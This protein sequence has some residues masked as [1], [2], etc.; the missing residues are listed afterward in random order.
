M[1]LVHLTAGTGNFH[2]GNCHRDN[3]LVKAL[4]RLGH[5][6]CIVPLYLPLVLDEAP[7]PGG[8]PLFAGGVNMFLQQ[9]ASLFRRTPRWLDHL[10]DNT[11]LLR[12]AAT[13][14]GMTR[15]EDL[16]EMTVETFRGLRGRQAKEWERLL[17]WLAQNNPDV[18]AFSNGLLAGLARDV[19]EH[20][21]AAVVCTLQGEDAFLDSL[22]EPHRTEAW[23]QM[24]DTASHV[25][26]FIGVS[27][28]YSRVMAERLRLPR[29]KLATVH[30]GID[31]ENFAPSPASPVNPAIGFLA[32][33]CHGKGLDTLVEAFVLLKQRGA[34]PGLRLRVAGAKTSADAAF[35]EAQEQKL[36]L[37]GFRKDTE[38]LPNI[39]LES[40]V[41]FLQS[42]SVFS[43]PATYGEAFGLSIIEALACGVPVVQPNH[44]AFPEIIG[45]TGGGVMCAPDDP[46]ALA[47][48]IEQ[49]LLTPGLASHLGELGRNGVVEH[50]SS[51]RMAQGFAAVCEAARAR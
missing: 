20:L 29:E 26:R 43:V 48:A 10:L 49:L 17:E 7:A 5:D 14:A 24:R 33:M 47:V 44:G 4:C 12:F 3:T 45:L 22:P 32:R 35:V 41:G 11:A 6:A 51:E 8:G 37:A 31:L 2:C 15:A 25:D 40:K 28:Y 36:N 42:L 34:L 38:F 23:Q 50:F 39:D 18:V 1:R 16:G 19:K 46:G 27:D 13:F 9:K 21:G 30:N